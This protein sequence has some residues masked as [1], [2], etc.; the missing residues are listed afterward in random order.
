MGQL[1]FFD[2]GLEAEPSVEVA[3]RSAIVTIEHRCT[4]TIGVALF[5]GGA[6]SQGKLVDR[7]DAAMYQ[8]KDDG[9][10]KIRFARNPLATI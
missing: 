1:A 6:V 4:A 2:E 7:A 3:C 5:C 9:R 10:N 8:P